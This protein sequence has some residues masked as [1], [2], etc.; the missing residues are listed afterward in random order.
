MNYNKKFKQENLHDKMVNPKKL[1]KENMEFI[2]VLV[3]N[4]VIIIVIM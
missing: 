1:I 3:V 2:N 4:I